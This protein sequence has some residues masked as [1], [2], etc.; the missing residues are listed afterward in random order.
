MVDETQMTQHNGHGKGSPLA[1]VVRDVRHVAHDVV[2][3]AE[4]QTSL[5]KT[6]LQGWWKQFIVP[7]VLLATVGI[8]VASCILILLASASLTLAE[9]ASISLPLALLLVA[10]GSLV[11]AGAMGAVAWGL[12]KKA[13]APLQESARELRQNVRWIKTVLRNVAHPSTFRTPFDES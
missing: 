13:R 7:V 8:L 10:L 11:T 5:A 2:E 12:I 9:S 6:E 1:A 4:L 3:L